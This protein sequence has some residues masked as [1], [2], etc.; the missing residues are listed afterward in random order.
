M[1][2]EDCFIA[3]FPSFFEN[4]L[5]KKVAMCKSLMEGKLKS[6]F[7]GLA[8]R[9]AANKASPYFVGDSITIAD[10]QVYAVIATFEQGVLSGFPET[11]VVDLAPSLKELHDHVLK[12]P[13]VKAYLDSRKK[14]KKN[15]GGRQTTYLLPSRYGD[16][17]KYGGVCVPT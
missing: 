9:L 3:S 5:E 8:A 14:L 1:M 4:D 11:V 16:A 7:E 6:L 17:R 12:H 15:V 10:L 2:A 13:K